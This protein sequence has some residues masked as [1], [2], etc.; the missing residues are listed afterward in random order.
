[1]VTASAKEKRLRISQLQVEMSMPHLPATPHSPS[2]LILYI[3]CMWLLG[4]S[5]GS[6]KYCPAVL[7]DHIPG[8]VHAGMHIHTHSTDHRRDRTHSCLVTGLSPAVTTPRHTPPFPAASPVPRAEQQALSSYEADAP[9]NPE[10]CPPLNR[11]PVPT[12]PSC[13]NKPH[14]ALAGP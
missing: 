6:E 11:A 7:S 13:E 14:W 2:R 9:P 1:M 10:H 4:Q 12:A 8:P 3:L 5:A